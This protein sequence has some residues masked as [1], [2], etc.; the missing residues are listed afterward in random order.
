MVAEFSRRLDG[1]AIRVIK[2][3][4]V[5]ALRGEHTGT[6][7]RVDNVNTKSL[8]IVID[9]VSVK[10]ADGSEVPRPVDPSNVVIIE[11][12]LEDKLREQKLGGE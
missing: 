8:K 12:N 3:D 9:G 11:L 4:K 5:K 10:K 2:G 1:L 7:G 6:E